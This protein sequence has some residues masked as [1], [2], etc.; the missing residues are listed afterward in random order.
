LIA[1]NLTCEQRRKLSKTA[2]YGYLWTHVFKDVEP[3]LSVDTWD[4]LLK[5]AAE[6]LVRRRVETGCPTF[7]IYAPLAK[8]VSGAFGPVKIHPIDKSARRERLASGVDALEKL[9]AVGMRDL[10]ELRATL[11]LAKRMDANPELLEDAASVASLGDAIRIIEDFPEGYGDGSK[12]MHYSYRA[13]EHL[14]LAC[15][16]LALTTGGGYADAESSNPFPLPIKMF[17][18]SIEEYGLAPDSAPLPAIDGGA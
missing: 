13:S 9:V 17:R 12:E 4:E 6:T 8:R 14:G 3:P 11:K 1:A 16:F 7:P 15:G 2:T 18:R 5:R 10:N